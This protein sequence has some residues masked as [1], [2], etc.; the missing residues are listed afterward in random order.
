MTVAGRTG[1][2]RESSPERPVPARIRTAVWAASVAVLALIGF[3]ALVRTASFLS[4]IVTTFPG[5]Y[6]RL[7]LL[8]SAAYLAAAVVLLLVAWR[9]ASWQRLHGMVLPVAIVILAVGVRVLLSAFAD[10]P[11]YGENRIIHQQALDVLDG[12]CCFSHRPLG[13][14]VSLAGAYALLGVGPSAVEALNVV[15]AAGTAFLVWDIGRVSWGRQVG[16]LAATAWAI[17]P[18]QVLMVLPPLTEPMYTLA[19][20][21]AMRAAIIPV[22]HPA[23]VAVLCG[24][25]LAAGQYVRATAG[26]LLVP[27][28]AV[29]WLIGWTLRRTVLRT[30]VI[31]AVYVVL[32]APVVAYNL[33]THGE[34]SVSTSAYGGWS[35]Y[36]GANRE[37][38]GRWNAEDA[39]RFA[40]FPG[41]SA[42]DK[43]EHAGTL[44]I[45]R[46]MEDPGG[47]IAL[48]PRK[49]MTLWADE[50][51]AAAYA[52]A[53]GPPTRAVHVG[54]LT[55]QLFWAPLVL[56]AGL[57]MFVGRRDPRAAALVIGM[58]V[59][60][61][62]VAHFALEVHS[63][64][65]AYLVPLLCLLGAVG[66]GALGRWW[67]DRR[68]TLVAG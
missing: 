44:V 20:V 59:T 55:S 39:A 34:L 64:Y 24:A 7:G 16:A 60:L 2:E 36:V 25:T 54:W 40:A 38:G 67:R 12:A 5:P 41:D 14:P 10:G 23:V 15:F 31:G 49:F 17:A 22:R 53:T 68:F 52:M 21:A 56:L 65:H 26:L 45:D 50:T 58:T 57:G 30:A 63:R 4:P 3:A 6:G 28:V 61:V 43:S 66:A 13:Y 29:P 11:L 51:Y 8:F 33:E 37:F 18:S 9:A 27:I 48:L 46:V 42:W 19:V 1:D 47:S 35:M 32:L 62:A